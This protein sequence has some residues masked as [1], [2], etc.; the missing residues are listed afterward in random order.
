MRARTT[1]VRGGRGG[2]RGA[3]L[4][5]VIVSVAILT[6]LAANL[7]Y[8]SRVSLEIAANA[9][10]ELRATYLA[11][12]GVA[13][14]RMVLGFQQQ[15]DDAAGAACGLLGQGLPGARNPPGAPQRPGGQPG[16]AA[17]PAAACPRPQIWNAV[18][19]SSVLVQSLFGGGEAAAAPAGAARAAATP[20]GAAAGGERT[21]AAFGEFDGAF[22]AKIE[23]EGRKVNAQLDARAVS[24]PARMQV[25]GL[26]QLIC[27][28]R[29]DRI[30]ERED[31]N[32]V[33]TSRQDLIVH[34]RDWIDDD[35]VS[36]SLVASFPGA[37]CLMEPGDPPF[38]PGFGDENFPYDK[39]E[40][41][42]RAKNARLDSI[43]ELYLVAGVSDVFMAAFGDRL[44]VYLPVEAPRNVNTSDR[45]DL[46]ELARLL[47]DPPAQPVLLDPEFGA[48][49]QQAI[50][51]QTTNGLMTITPLQFAATVEALGVRVN[52]AA[53]SPTSGKQF[54]TDRSYVFRIRS[55]GTAGAV[56]KSVDAV[57][58]FDPNQNRDTQGQPQLQVPGQNPAQAQAL[59]QLQTQAQQLQSAATGVKP[60]RLLRWREE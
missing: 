29:W 56:T 20:A 1:A 59:A 16:G 37:A 39:G 26:Y 11:K 46:V 51:D 49:L 14:S 34:L 33:R 23:D 60:N 19:V 42:Y 48:K 44:T 7:A 25:L 45:R 53:L 38:E 28:P 58:T 40:D 57:V 2:E 9:R 41:R 55:T 24:G 12:S 47:A 4:L 8:E 35:K 54:L 10:D 3:A 17:Q 32:R 13:L 52:T 15:I 6:A 27:D 36:S 18:P 43:E 5:V 50:A 31:A 30:F 22:E 21:R